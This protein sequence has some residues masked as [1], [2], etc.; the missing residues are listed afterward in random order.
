[1]VVRVAGK[2]VYLDTSSLDRK[3][4]V[5]D[6]FKIILSA[7]RLVNPKT[8]KDLGPL[9]NYS[10]EG[11]ITEVQPLYAV[12]TLPEALPVTVGQE[13]VLQEK[14]APAKEAAAAP[15]NTPTPSSK[16]KLVYA[17]TNQVIISLSEGPVLA[18]YTQNIITLSDS[19][20][21]TVWTR[22]KETLRENITY[23]L[24]SLQKPLSVSAAKL[25]R[26]EKADIFVS[27]FD[28][29]QNRIFTSILQEQ[30]NQL[31]EIASIPYYVKEHGCADKKELWA[32]RAF[33]SGAYPG[34]ARKLI[35]ENNQF[36]P[37]AQT[38]TTQRNWLPS[39]VW[40][41]VEQSQTENFIYTSS[42]GKI[43]LTLE[44]GKQAESK[45]LF[46]ASPNRVKYKQEVVKFYPSLQVFGT[47]GNAT[48]VGVE[49]TSK[50]GILSSTFGQYKNGKIHFLAYEKGRLNIKDS[51]EF[52]GVIYDTACT[53][54]TLLTAEV[55]PNGTSSVVEIF[56]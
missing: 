25:S 18:E 1:M 39:A 41:P 17:P 23:Q 33:V 24:P 36:V 19:G 16:N 13:A 51:L 40:F 3:V 11:K 34:S 26:A 54:N 28:A 45:D 29:R 12:G 48:I 53:A 55:L 30:D 22:A 20:L 27:Y 21:V 6:S 50:L 14:P 7:E 32:Q 52:D 38:Y 47:A 35:Y 10:A 4:N 9:Y 5:G 49:N 15:Q 31:K 2:N 42:G 43:V 46:A 8:G 56:N 37:S 44:N